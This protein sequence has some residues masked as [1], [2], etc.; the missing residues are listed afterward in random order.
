MLRFHAPWWLRLYVIVVIGLLCESAQLRWTKVSGV[1]GRKLNVWVFVGYA[2]YPL[3]EGGA[4]IPVD[5]SN[6]EEYL[7]AVISATL[8]KGI[9]AQMKAFRF[10]PPFPQVS[11]VQDLLPSTAP[12][13]F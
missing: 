13:G 1:V 6:V 12:E 4:D 3:K 9:E 10:G 5:K 11:K 7:T 2:D 8:G